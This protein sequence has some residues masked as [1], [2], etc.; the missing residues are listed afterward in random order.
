MSSSSNAEV[1]PNTRIIEMLNVM[2]Q[3]LDIIEARTNVMN[4]PRTTT[5]SAAP[6]EARATSPA[7]QTVH[8]TKGITMLQVDIVFEHNRCKNERN[9]WSICSIH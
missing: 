7:Q 5:T 4:L 9:K 8:Q 3:R 2:S 6:P 1:D